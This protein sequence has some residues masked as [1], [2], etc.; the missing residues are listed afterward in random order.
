MRLTIDG[1]QPCTEIKGHTSATEAPKDT[2]AAK[3]TAQTLS[4]GTTADGKEVFQVAGA[5]PTNIS[6]TPE[7]RPAAPAPI[8]EVD[9]LNV[10]VAVGTTCR[11]KGCGVSFVSDEV[12][13][14]GDGEGT[15]C[16]HHPLP[17]SHWPSISH[18]AS[19]N[20]GTILA[21]IQRG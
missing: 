19:T 12:N 14:H 10:P 3:S 21:N 16:H 9:D 6:S 20:L 13:R 5:P 7:I 8:L 2:P 1:V 18:D 4:T 17:V 15:V 11:R